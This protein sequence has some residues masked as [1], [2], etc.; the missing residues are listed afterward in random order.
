MVLYLGTW[1]LIPVEGQDQSPSSRS[2]QRFGRLPGLLLIIA[3]AAFLFLV[4]FPAVKGVYFD[5]GCSRSCVLVVIGIFLLRR[6]GP[7]GTA[8]PAGHRPGS[9]RASAAAP[10]R[11]RTTTVVEPRPRAPR[12]PLGWYIT[13]ATLIAIGVA[14]MLDRPR[15]WPCCRA[16]TSAW[17]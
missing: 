12:S 17:R 15:T 2:L 14:A 9:D 6:G 16:S 8:A 13:A 1:L 10:M 11:R 7:A 3:A 5:G 4:V